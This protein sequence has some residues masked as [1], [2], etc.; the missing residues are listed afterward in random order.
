LIPVDGAVYGVLPDG[1]FAFTLT[2]AGRYLLGLDRKLELADT[3][4]PVAGVIVQPNFDVVFLAPSPAVEAAIARFAERVAAGGVGTLFRLTPACVRNAV[5]AGLTADH[6]LEQLRQH[7]T[8]PIPENVEREL[9]GW[10][11]ACRRVRIGPAL[12]V[13]CPDEETAGLVLA[14]AGAYGRLIAPAIVEITDRKQRTALEK[15]LRARGVFCDARGGKRSQR[16]RVR[17]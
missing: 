12:L 13:R 10:C 15:K 6:M 11:A 4:E 3:T 17:R 8:K 5:G 1:R 9:R 16:A 2:P 14:A 7:S